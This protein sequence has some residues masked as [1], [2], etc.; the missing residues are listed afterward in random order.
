M[1]LVQWFRLIGDRFGVMAILALAA[2][3]RLWNLGYPK[4]LVFDETYYVKDAH[5][6][7]KMAKIDTLVF[8]KTGTITY[9]KKAN[10]SF[11]G[12][13]IAEF[14]LKNIK[15]NTL[16]IKTKSFYYNL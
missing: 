16:T 12:Q 3:T 9:N 14:D 15:S 7:E 10:I 13:E 8:D 5:T 2:I 1:R 11:E 6:I 4:T